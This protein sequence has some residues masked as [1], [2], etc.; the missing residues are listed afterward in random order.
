MLNT[1]AIIAL[2][3]AEIEKAGGIAAWSATTGVEP[4]TV[5]EVLSKESP[6]TKTIIKALRSPTQETMDGWTSRG[7][8]ESAATF[9]ILIGVGMVI[10]FVLMMWFWL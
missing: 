7:T 9:A 4:A 2:L 3:R 8:M 1:D 6:P 10:G 5:R